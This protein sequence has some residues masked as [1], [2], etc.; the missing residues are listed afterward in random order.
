MKHLTILAALVFLVSLLSIPLNALPA[1]GPGPLELTV[2]PDKPVEGGD[3]IHIRLANGH[4]KDHVFL[5]S[6]RKIAPTPFAGWKLLIN[7]RRAVHLGK[8]PASG[9]LKHHFKLPAN[10]PPSASGQFRFYQAA[11]MGKRPN[12]QRPMAWRESNIEWIR[13]K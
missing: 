11:S 2:K 5:F 1:N 6:G 12:P 7:P 4:E 10:I 3:V 9:E 8:F 13:F